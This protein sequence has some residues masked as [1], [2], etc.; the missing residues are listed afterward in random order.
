MA[1]IIY[2]QMLV[3]EKGGQRASKVIKAFLLFCSCVMVTTT[4]L[5]YRN[6]LEWLDFVYVCSYLKLAITIKYVPQVDSA[7]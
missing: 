2:I 7:F 5:V 3:Y 4:I 6:K 1:V